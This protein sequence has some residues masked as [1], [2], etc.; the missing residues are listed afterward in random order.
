MWHDGR[1]TEEYIDNRQG[2]EWVAAHA[3]KAAVW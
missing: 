1:M 3:V 2:Q